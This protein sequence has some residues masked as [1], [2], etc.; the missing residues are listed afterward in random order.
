MGKPIANVDGFIKGAT[1]DQNVN[2]KCI[3]SQHVNKHWSTAEW[4]HAYVSYPTFALDW[5]PF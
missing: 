5:I 4:S 3:L 2:V 1:K